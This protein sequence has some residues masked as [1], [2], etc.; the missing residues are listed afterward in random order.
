MVIPV[1]EVGLMEDRLRPL[2]SCRYFL[3]EGG[4][5]IVWACRTG[6]YSLLRANPSEAVR[7]ILSAAAREGRPRLWGGAAVRSPDMARPDGRLREFGRRAPEARARRAPG[8]R[9]SA[10]GRYPPPV[11]DHMAELVA[12]PPEVRVE[13]L[14]F[15]QH[16]QGAVR[17]LSG[18]DGGR[19]SRFAP[20]ASQA[21]FA[22][23]SAA[24]S[25]LIISKH[26]QRDRGRPPA[27]AFDERMRDAHAPPPPAGAILEPACWVRGA[28]LSSGLRCR[29]KN[30]VLSGA[31]GPRVMTC[32][33]TPG[34]RPMPEPDEH[35]CHT[36][37]VRARFQ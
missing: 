14:R 29:S 28:R 7:R 10:S 12:E 26:R 15:I 16:A 8:V 24:K 33:V 19:A 34:T 31:N 18:D 3:G 22:A 35:A 17:C 4:S 9:L 36:L 13:H 21:A 37:Y 5:G 2:D 25:L 30:A 27:E 1:V 23:L 32:S 6:T 11:Q 20:A